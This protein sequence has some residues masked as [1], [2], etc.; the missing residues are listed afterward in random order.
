MSEF[1]WKVG[2]GA[3]AWIVARW[4]CDEGLIRAQKRHIA[5]QADLA[6][7]N[8]ALIFQLQRSVNIRDRQLGDDPTYPDIETTIT[9]D[10]LKERYEL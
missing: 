2:G 8:D 6:D 4:L 5:A 3:G 10:D 9:L 7:A 1:L